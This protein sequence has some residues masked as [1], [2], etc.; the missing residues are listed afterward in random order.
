[1]RLTLKDIV[2]AALLLLIVWELCLQ[3]ALLDKLVNAVGGAIYDLS[4]PIVEV[5]E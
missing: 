2:I 4:T 1:M 5:T 3:V